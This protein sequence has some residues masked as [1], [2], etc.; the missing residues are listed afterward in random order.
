MLS[1]VNESGYNSKQP[2]CTADGKYLFFASDRKEGLGNFDIWYAPLRA[3]GTTGEPVNAGAVLN[4][5]G[6]EQ[7][8]FYH[9][10]SDALVFASDR[11]PGM[12]GYDLFISKGWERQWQAPQNMGYPI[13]SSRDDLYFS[14]SEM[15]CHQHLL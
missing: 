4:T 14:S 11:A 8:P 6:N 15:R 12:G 9:S 2:F 7:A 13:N 5:A 10:A 3:D 1:S